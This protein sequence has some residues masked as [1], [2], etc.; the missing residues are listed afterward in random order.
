MTTILSK[1]EFLTTKYRT[2]N[3]ISK[4]SDLAEIIG[5]SKDELN[6]CIETCKKGGYA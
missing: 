2:K 3:I 6:I 5:I 1:A 4:L